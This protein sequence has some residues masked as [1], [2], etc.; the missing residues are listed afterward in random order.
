MKNLLFSIVLFCVSLYAAANQTISVVGTVTDENTGLAVP[1]QMIFIYSDSTENCPVYFNTVFTGTDGTY[2][3]EFTMATICAQGF[4]NIFTFDCNG[5]IQS[6]L[7]PYGPGNYDLTADLQ[8]CSGGIQPYDCYA[9]FWW[10]Q[11]SELNVQFEDNSWPEPT[12]WN[13]NFGDGQ[14]SSEQNPVHQFAETGIYTVSLSIY[15]EESGCTSSSSYEVWVESYNFDCQAWFYWN[16]TMLDPSTIEFYDNSWFIPGS[17]NWQFGDGQYAS[18]QNPVHNYAEPGLYEVT[19]MINSADSSCFDQYTDFVNVVGNPNSCIADFWW[20]QTGLTSIQFQNSSIPLNIIAFWDFGDGTTSAEMNPEH[21][22]G[23]Q[24]VYQVCLT[25]GDPVINCQDSRCYEVWVD[26]TGYLECKADFY[27]WQ[28]DNL[29]VE[30]QDF[31]WPFPV[32][33]EWNFGDG[34]FSSE[35]NPIHDYAATGVYAVSLTIYVE[36]TGCVSITTHEVVVEDFN[37][38]CQAWFYWNQ[39]YIEPLTVEFYDLSWFIPGTWNWDFGDGQF[40]VEQ[41]PVHT[42]AGP[43][44]YEVTLTINGFDSTCYDQYIKAVEVEGYPYGCHA[45]FLWYQ[46]DTSSIQFQNL[47]YPIN[48]FSQWDFGDGTTST[49]QNPEH[50]FPSLGVYL[51]CLTTLNSGLNCTDTCCYEVWIGQNAN[52]QA[53]YFW[54][55]N[56]GMPLTIQF[57]DMSV[58]NGQVDWLW[59]FGDGATSGQ[60][61]PVHAFTTGEPYQVCLSISSPNTSCFSQFCS[62]V[63]FG[64][65]VPPDCYNDF[66]VINQG[67]LS[68]MFMGIMLNTNPAEYFWD[69]GDGASGQGQTVNHTFAQPGSYAVCLTT[70]STSP[71]DSCFYTSCKGV[72]AGNG[73]SAM[74]AGF[75]MQ[76]DSINGMIYHFF[77]TSTGYPVF[78]MWDFGDG[79]F[80]TDQNPTHEYAAYGWYEVCLTI[81]GQGLT[82]TYCTGFEMSIIPLGIASPDHSIVIGNIYPNPNNGSFTIDVFLAKQSEIIISV[83][84]YLGQQV[85]KKKRTMISGKTRLNIDISGM[86]NGIYSVIISGEN[87]Q[88]TKKFIIR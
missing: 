70:I 42:Y 15:V 6:Q 9:D 23:G 50:V 24:G 83:M 85:F 37:F 2:A 44:I 43:G 87:Q 66:N 86:P 45:D 55:P 10:W 8:I 29:S 30:F 69:F 80:S 31:S 46:S 53:N 72:N 21:T 32:S 59:D 78:W 62:E 41:N 88:T 47:S 4:L 22:F 73:S 40:S 51:V 63:N 35:Q 76:A 60:Q 34:Q 79:T 67:N 81:F 64:G 68:F 58:Y 38:D 48:S 74:Q 3:D 14:T 12:T 20:Y 71:A 19:L 26:S 33:W 25:I 18:E 57:Y 17:W 77:D 5:I 27:W 16:P 1:E 7:L 84:N 65:I 56:P 54:T 36:E 39:S 28:M 49:E 13:W 52:C 61:N 75:I 11:N 82:D